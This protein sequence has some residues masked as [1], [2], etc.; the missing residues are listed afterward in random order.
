MAP[1][2]TIDEFEPRGRRVLLRADLNVP[3][4]AGHVTDATRLVRLAPTI[5]TLA[6]RGAR[7]VLLSHFGRPKGKPDP[8]FS[9]KPLTAP[10]A[11][12]IGRPVAFA[13]D[14]VGPSAERVVAAAPRRGRGAPRESPLSS[15]KKRPTIA[16]LRRGSRRSAIST[17]TTPFPRRIARMPRPKRWRICCRRRRDG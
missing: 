13:E 6:E 5:K 8:A 9:L 7:V 1:F 4:A 11:A 3:M 14:C 15:G 2:K 17:S 16:A 12:V 10:L